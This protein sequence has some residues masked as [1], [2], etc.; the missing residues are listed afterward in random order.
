MNRQML[1]ALLPAVSGVLL[2]SVALFA[3]LLP[4]VRN[5]LIDTKMAMVQSMAQTAWSVL[6]SLH[7]RV[8]RGELTLEE[9]QERGKSVIHSMRH[10]EAGRNY[11][12][13]IDYDGVIKVHPYRPDHVGENQS[14]LR[15]K[16]G[17]FFVA[18][19]IRLARAEGEGL[20]TYYWQ[21]ADDPEHVDLKYSYAKD[22]RPWG[23]VLGTGVYMADVQ[24]EMSLITRDATVIGLTLLLAVTAAVIYL[25]W[26]SYVLGEEKR[27]AEQGLRMTQ[28]A[29]DNAKD[30]CIWINDQG[31]IVYANQA[32][33]DSHGYT[34]DEMLA[35]RIFDIDVDYAETAFHQDKDVLVRERKRS[36]ETRHVTKDGRIFPVEVSLTYFEY[37]G[38]FYSIGF[39][40]DISERK[41]SEASL[42][43]SEERFRNLAQLL[44]VAVF[45]AD[46]EQ[47][48]V[49]ANQCAFDIFGYVEEDAILGM[50][51][52]AFIVPEERARAAD[53]L[54]ARIRGVLSGPSEYLGLRKDGSH[55]P[56]LMNSTVVRS[57][58]GR[59]VKIIGAITDISALK[60]A[61]ERLSQSESQYRAL[62]ENSMDTIMRFDTQLRHV[63][64]NRAVDEQTG[65][66]AEQ[67][68]G[69]THAELG[70]PPDLTNLADETLARV[71]AT[72]TVQRV[73]FMLPNGIWIDWLCVPE[74]D[75]DGQVRG[76]VT[77][78]RDITERKRVEEELRQANMVVENSPVVLFRW[79]AAENWPVIMVSQN[80]SQFGYV[81][82]EILSGAV[83]YSDLVHP[84]DL[85]RMNSEIEQYTSANIDRYRQEY[86]LLTSGG[87]VRWVDDRTTVIRGKDGRIEEFQGIVLDI[88]ERK[89]A[90][91]ALAASRRMLDEVVNTIPVRVYWKDSS[92]RYLGGNRLFALDMGRDDPG[93]LIGLDDRHP[94]WNGDN[95]GR[96][97]DDRAVLERGEEI[98]NMETRLD[99]PSGQA[100]WQRASKIPLRDQNGQIYGILGVYDDITEYKKM[101]E[102]MIQTEK[103]ISVG[104]IAAG[105]AHEINNPLGIVLQASQNLAL[106][107]QPDFPKNMETARELGLDMTV[108][109]RYVQRRKL[110]VFLDD[111]QSAAKRAAIII[112][113]MLDFTRR[114]ESRRTLCAPSQIVRKA[115]SLVQSDYDLKK[116]YDFKKI[117]VDIREDDGL[118]MILCT[119]T[120]IEQVVLN[121]LRNAAQAMAEVSPALEDPHIDIRLTSISGGVRM[122]L[123]DNGPGIPGEIL[124]RIFEPF[125]TTKEPGKGTGLGLSVSYF[126]ITQGHGGRMYVES[127]PGAGTCFTIELPVES[128]LGEDA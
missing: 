17:L 95:Q 15:D 76:V 60:A 78:A 92:M 42:R 120:E 104:G 54:V 74:K 18:E 32:A 121:V 28:F 10:D 89:I 5:S 25:S 2:I 8:E 6:Q 13:I 98:R 46:M 30:S 101:Q 26:R 16:N 113:Q 64:V 23:W 91:E 35:L 40:R 66:P 73:E 58:E 59:P 22:F 69:K 77:T 111:I 53:N 1:R 103:M 36:F 124:G 108:F 110:D 24:R 27:K 11:F 126:I 31:R 114:S 71:I 38:R 21:V 102:M 41:K 99:L 125:F 34:M 63:Y 29:V 80:I 90:E 7:E 47:R 33:C 128:S 70:F 55:F 75:S 48:L 85:D 123:K 97:L 83:K 109:A 116:N 106:R 79:K 12:W 68:I 127:T 81:R 87:E 52:L 88:T 117:R 49:F 3:L 51:C 39:D 93:Q 105:I 122:E 19:M 94:A 44:P 61:E 119:E 4:K 100:V 86:R 107:M 118:P 43:Q 57:E 82:E 45:E 56:L 67:W 9:A 62:A 20:V 14:H 96:L 84:D 50:A 65:I 72:G 115:L 112:R 37:E